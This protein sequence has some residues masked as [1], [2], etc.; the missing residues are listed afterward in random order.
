MHEISVFS[1]KT[2]F[3]FFLNREYVIH[4]NEINIFIFLF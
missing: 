3:V 1:F 4:K 2:I